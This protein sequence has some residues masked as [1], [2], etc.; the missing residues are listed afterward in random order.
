MHLYLE[1]KGDYRKGD[2]IKLENYNKHVKGKYNVLAAIEDDEECVKMYQE[3]G[4][5]VLQPK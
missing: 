4:I 1:L 3:Q 2:V 5:F